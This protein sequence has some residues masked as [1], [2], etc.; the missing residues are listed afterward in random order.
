MDCS[1]LHDMSLGFVVAFIIFGILQ[2]ILNP[3]A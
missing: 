1:F 3:N 2:I